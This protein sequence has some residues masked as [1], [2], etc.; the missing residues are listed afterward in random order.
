MKELILNE[1][2]DYT[3]EELIKIIQN[4]I[5]VDMQKA[6]NI[7]DEIIDFIDGKINRIIR[8]L[9]EQGFSGIHIESSS[10]GIYND[11][12]NLGQWIAVYRFYS[13]TLGEDVYILIEPK[14]G[15]K[16]FENMLNDV[17]EFA[18]TYGLPS[19][20]IIF[21]GIFSSSSVKRDILYSF[22]LSALTELAIMEG[23]PIEIE[24]E[25]KYIHGIYGKIDFKGYIKWKVKNVFPMKRR[26]L[27]YA[28]LPRIML[29]K[30][31]Q[32]LLEELSNEKVKYENKIGEISN[33]L[34]K[35][36][37]RHAYFLSMEHLFDVYSQAIYSF[38]ETPETIE[39]IIHASSTK[40]FIK[41]ISYLYLA[42]LM[43]KTPLTE[44]VLAPWKEEIPIMPLPSA[45]VY[46]LWNLK[47]INDEFVKMFN[48]S[49]TLKENG[50]LVFLYDHS[51]LLFNYIY[52]EWSNLIGKAISHLPRPDYV[53]SMDNSRVIIDAKYRERGNIKLE[54][55][56]RML[57]Y[58]VDIASPDY[59]ELAGC[60]I[61]LKDTNSNV[62]LW[63]FRSDIEPK[64]KIYVAVADPRERDIAKQ[65]I[66]KLI[67][68]VIFKK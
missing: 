31:H 65:N 64:I 63:T 21:Q 32:T 35:Y 9:R 11:R 25:K 2:I 30:F 16:A 40:E 52:S 45:K 27:A 19:L 54:D 61:T 15:K 53:I 49:K 67:K 13:K 57:S 38:I 59:P 62:N 23:L 46:E 7:Y 50:G 3:K 39:E 56:E 4:S 51:K 26:K 33:I 6:E 34:N 24:E 60:F 14:I 58:V 22:L 28:K 29:V 48:F 18:L 36:I 55:F 12:L 68:E 1:D 8:Q 20:S 66:Q 5:K 42:Y 43:E 47:L 37:K 17:V 41:I 44:H 10:P